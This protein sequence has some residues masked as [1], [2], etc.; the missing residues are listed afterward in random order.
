[1]FVWL[2]VRLSEVNESRSSIVYGVRFWKVGLLFTVQFQ[3][4]VLFL[5]SLSFIG[6]RNA[7]VLFE[8]YIYLTNL[9]EWIMND[10]MSANIINGERG[11][12]E[13]TGDE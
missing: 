13:Y 2:N 9:N 4:F 12:Y 3:C 1:M 6:V 11:E 8:C 5:R 10:F 7:S